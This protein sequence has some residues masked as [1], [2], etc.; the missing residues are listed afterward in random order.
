[1]LNFRLSKQQMIVEKHTILT[2]IHSWYVDVYL[3]FENDQTYI[4]THK[5]AGIGQQTAV[6]ILYLIF[7]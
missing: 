4:S 3:Y 6:P 2:F 1:M 5:E 7:C